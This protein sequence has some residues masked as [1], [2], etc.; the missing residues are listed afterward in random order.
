MKE[1]SKNPDYETMWKVECEINSQL[2]VELEE[3]QRLLDEAEGIILVFLE[4][5]TSVNKLSEKNKVHARQ[6]ISK[7]NKTR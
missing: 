2:R 5:G 7:Y 3:K 6:F 1:L 4:V